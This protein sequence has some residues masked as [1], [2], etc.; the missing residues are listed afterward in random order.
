MLPNGPLWRDNILCNVKVVN[1]YIRSQ[2]VFASRRITRNYHPDGLL[3]ILLSGGKFRYCRSDAS[4]PGPL[5]I[6]ARIIIILLREYF[7]SAQYTNVLFNQF[8]FRAVKL[9]RVPTSIVY[10]TYVQNSHTESERYNVFSGF[11]RKVVVYYVRL[12]F[13]GLFIYYKRI[14]KRFTRVGGKIM[15][16]F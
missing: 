9:F 13:H 7:T 10:E 12:I 14:N 1:V 15:K 16:I 3:I 8:V 6:S 2:S 11:S 5:T 4:F